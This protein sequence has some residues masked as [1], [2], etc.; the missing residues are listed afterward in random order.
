MAFLEAQDLAC[1]SGA[2]SLLR[3]PARG[4]YAITP[5]KLVGQ[6]LLVAVNAAILGGA[7]LVQYRA[8]PPQLFCLGKTSNS[9]LSDAIALKALCDQKKIPLIVNDDLALAARLQCG[10]HLGEFDSSVREART[11]L[12]PDAIIGASCYDSVVLAQRA[13]EAGASY[14]AFGAFFPSTS[15]DQPRRASA[16]ILRKAAALGLPCAAIG[17]LNASNAAP[18]IDAGADYI[19]VIS[20]I[21][22][23]PDI[24]AATLELS[25][26]FHA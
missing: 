16:Q 13:A 11:L 18:I 22:D 4:V 1:E 21:F 25:R 15:K 17:G 20:A 5:E 12:G 7:V 10:V 8:K 9:N 2:Q 24:A 3:M 19:A 6:E 14:V 26:L 23:Q